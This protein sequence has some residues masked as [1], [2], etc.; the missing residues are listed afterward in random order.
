MTT[1][2]DNTH[3]EVNNEIT[4]APTT[5]PAHE[6]IDVELENKLDEHDMAS[7][8]DHEEEEITAAWLDDFFDDWIDV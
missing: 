3:E 1:I 2:S 4:S 6:N 5:N 8:Q 7:A